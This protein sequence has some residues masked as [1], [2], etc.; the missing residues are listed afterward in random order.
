MNFSFKAILLRGSRSLYF[1][2]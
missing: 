2:W 1:I